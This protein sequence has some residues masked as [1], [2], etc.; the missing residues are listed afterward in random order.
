LD[1]AFNGNDELTDVSCSGSGKEEDDEQ[2]KRQ[3]PWMDGV[4][5][6]RQNCGKDA[7]RS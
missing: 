2:D 3:V 7:A 5:D 4:G 6:G 1:T